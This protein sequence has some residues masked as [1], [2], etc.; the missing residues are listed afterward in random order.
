MMI[1][2]KKPGRC[3][4]VQRLES[5]SGKSSSRPA[6]PVNPERSSRGIVS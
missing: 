5:A 3:D 1:I 2:S 6:I 4:D